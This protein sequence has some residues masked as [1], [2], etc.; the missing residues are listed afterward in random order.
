[1][2]S[3]IVKGCSYSWKK[4]DPDIIIH[5][6]PKDLESIKKWLLQTKQ[7]YGDIEEFSRRIL[8]GTKGAYRVCSQHF[9][10][11]SYETRGFMTMLKKGAVPTI[12]PDIPVNTAKYKRAK[13]PAKRRKVDSSLSSYRSVPGVGCEPTAWRPSSSAGGVLGVGYEP[14]AT[15]WCPS[16]NARG[17]LG[18]GFEPAATTWH[19]ASMAGGIA[20]VRCEPTACRPASMATLSSHNFI[21]HIAGGDLYVQGL[22]MLTAGGRLDLHHDQSC[23]LHSNR[24]N[25]TEETGKPHYPGLLSARTHQSTNT[26]PFLGTSS[27]KVQANLRKKHSSVG[28]QCNPE[29]LPVTHE[30]R[31]FPLRISLRNFDVLIWANPFGKKAQ[32]DLDL[33]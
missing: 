28:N 16:S 32:V 1:M 20:G 19:L 29:D 12:F 5:A 26:E 31:R 9:T 14:A 8:E 6:F 33:V 2:P 27:K 7:D 13:V 18:G 4:K 23:S 30:R 21:S 3:C 17:V 25:L 11:D 15:A 22:C 10:S 24:Q